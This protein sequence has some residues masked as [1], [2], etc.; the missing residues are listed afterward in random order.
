MLSREF[1]PWLRD[2][3]D[4]FIS[5]DTIVYFVLLASRKRIH[6]S[7]D[8]RLI[9]CLEWLDGE[10]TVAN[11]EA[12]FRDHFPESDSA[13]LSLLAF[14][15]YLRDKAIVVEKDWMRAELSD[16]TTARFSRQLNFF[17][18]ME[19]SPCSA[20][21]MFHRIRRSRIA[22]FGLGSIGSWMLTELLQVGF[23]RFILV[24]PDRVERFDVARHAFFSTRDIGRFKAHVAADH[25]RDWYAD[26]VV[27]TSTQALQVNSDVG[28]FVPAQCDVIV[29]TADEPY[30]GATSVKLSRY[31]L[32]Q[33]VPLLV[34]GGFDAHLGS[35]G[36]LIVPWRTPCAD[37]YASFFGDALKGWKPSPHPV[38][39]RTG[40][41]G[42]LA[43]LS[44]FS[45]S[46]ST[47][48]LLQLFSG[49]DLDYRGSRGELMFDD[50]SLYDF[51]VP[52]DPNCQACA[53]SVLGEA[54]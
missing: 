26:C 9:S 23:R 1:R 31:C 45:A 29:N 35:V 2:S 43:M 11:L 16:E 15:E 25:V 19:G 24:D 6:V 52:R 54:S 13:G 50:Y 44:V 17:L 5:S 46:A 21:S 38:L 51:E 41:F 7:A 39:D 20:L 53:S 22:I 30:V 27:S 10:T 32:R 42:G 3:V 28:D 18:D 12:R 34:A 14:L 36:E 47:A 33:N 8:S 40:G 4:V 49:R 37:C 48:K